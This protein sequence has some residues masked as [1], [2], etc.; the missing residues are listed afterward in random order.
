T[1]CVDGRAGISRSKPTTRR[2]RRRDFIRSPG[3]ATPV[4]LITPDC[5]RREGST[6]VPPCFDTGFRRRLT[7]W[8]KVPWGAVR[9]MPFGSQP[10]RRGIGGDL[11][12][13]LHRARGQ[14]TRG[15]G[16]I[17][18]PTRRRP[19]VSANTNSVSCVLS[20]QAVV[21]E[22]L[23]LFSHATA[24]PPSTSIAERVAIWGG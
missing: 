22:R 18:T 19:I 5:L 2:I 15:S 9:S 24:L 14:R 11:G 6:K 4:S 16:A 3:L 17:L 20:L 7:S 23:R 8:G 10:A 13:L 12:G 21:D 1:V